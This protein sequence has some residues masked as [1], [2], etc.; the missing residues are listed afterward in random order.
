MQFDFWVSILYCHL[1]YHFSKKLQDIV[2]QS[3][4]GFFCTLCTV[5]SDAICWLW[6]KLPCSH[7]A[8]E[9][10][11]VHSVMCI[12]IGSEGLFC[13]IYFWGLQKGFSFI[14]LQNLNQFGCNS[15]H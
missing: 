12:I 11:T 5:H 15:E 3:R 7:I 6:T 1:S 8:W 14:T 2:L 13:K 9:I 4:P 10:V